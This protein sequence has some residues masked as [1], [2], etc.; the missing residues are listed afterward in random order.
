MTRLNLVLGLLGAVLLSAPGN[1]AESTAPESI[2]ISTGS[3]GGVYD[4]Y[5]HG[6]AIMLTNIWVSPLP[7]SRPRDPCRM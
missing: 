2:T 5:G 3:P 1:A 6:L 4:P 7:T